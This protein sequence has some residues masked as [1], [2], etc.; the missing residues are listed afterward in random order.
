MKKLLIV[1]LA[2]SIL[3]GCASS[4]LDYKTGTE[5][6]QIQMSQFTAGK[7]SQPQVV[8]SVGRPNRKE[9]LASK[10]LWYYDYTKISAFLGGHVNESTVFEW[11]TSG[12]LLEVYKTG[13]SSK[14]GNPLLDAANGK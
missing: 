13:R 11:N 5:I 8:A 1:S 3:Y 2:S 12:K 9:A 6:T 4:P 10:E 7:T 14:T